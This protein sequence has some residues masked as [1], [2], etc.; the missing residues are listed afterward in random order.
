MSA[1]RSLSDLNSS[2]LSISSQKTLALPG[3]SSEGTPSLLGAKLGCKHRSAVITETFR[4]ARE[5]V[6]AHYDL[7]D[8]FHER[9]RS[10]AAE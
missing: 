2:R 5:R 3:S 7:D 9:S 1:S 8:A 10:S 6:K 4:E